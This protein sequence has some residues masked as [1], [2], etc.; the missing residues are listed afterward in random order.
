MQRLNFYKW[1]LCLLVFE[2][3]FAA[4]AISGSLPRWVTKVPSDKE[5]LYFVGISTGAQALENGKRSAVKQAIAELTEQFETRSNTRFSER[6]TELE[7]KL[8]DEIDSYSSNV[9]IKGSFLKDWYFEKTKDGRYDV[10]VLIQ[11]PKAELERER[12][13]IQNEAAEKVAS[14]R[15]ALGQGDLA[16]RSGDAKGAY[17]AF[18]GALKGAVEV[19]DAGLHSEALGRLR[20]LLEGIQIK[21]VA[22]NG[23]KGELYKGLKEPIVAK[24][25]V[26]DGGVE[27]PVHGAP[28]FFSAGGND[29]HSE[30]VLTDEKGLVS[31]KLT[32]IKTS[33]GLAINAALDVDQL[34]SIPG[35]IPASDRDF[36]TSY[37]TLLKSRS[38]TFNFDVV[39]A[40]KNVRVIVLVREEN[41]GKP[42]EESV[43]GNELAAALIE[44][45]YDV[46]GGQEIGRY[47]TE[48]IRDAIDK[49]QLTYLRREFY[50]LAD[51]VVAGTVK[52][53]NGGDNKGWTLSSYA[54]G[55][56]KAVNLGT[57]RIM[58]QKNLTG[59]VGFGDT[60]E[61]ATKNAL[62]K[63]ADEIKVGLLE[64][65]A[66]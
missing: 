21:A 52:T 9:R 39:T 22:G 40:K 55:Y 6:R 42:V 45:G 59:V 66:E 56:V 11:Y 33:K 41:L 50:P 12:A 28:V 49:K 23:Q 25:F 2:L 27:T 32:T 35:W 60:E 34:F 10:Y 13:R 63:I 18:L 51:V 4:N 65:M 24:V 8:L 20:R 53:R 37:L 48:G 64:G 15:K 19:E 7:T 30:A 14:V 5:S 54:D 29:E 57:G 36:V 3:I 62:N 17:T 16:L 26:Q 43:V 1:S 47:D 38:V 58:A 31:Y 46:I 61:K 44:A